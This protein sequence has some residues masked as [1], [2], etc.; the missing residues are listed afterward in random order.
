M[1]Q[2]EVEVDG[3]DE[4]VAAAAADEGADAARDAV[5]TTLLPK[6]AAKPR[7]D[8]PTAVMA[9]GEA[10]G[11]SG[12]G[13]QAQPSDSAG[14]PGPGRGPIQ[15]FA[16]DRREQDRTGDRDGG[17]GCSRRALLFGAG[18][19]GVGAA[20][21]A[22]FDRLR[23][24]GNA[25]SKPTTGFSPMADDGRS[26]ATQTCSAFLEAWASGRLV[27]A[28]NI[29]DDPARA[30]AALT[31]YQHELGVSGMVITPDGANSV[32]RMTFSITAQ[33]GKPA[34][35]WAYQSALGAYQRQVQG[36]TRWFVQWDPAILYSS[37]KTG[38]QL[39][40][41]KV[42]ATIKGLTDRSGVPISPAEH[43]SLAGFVTSLVRSTK[44]LDSTA[45]QQI[46][47]TDAGGEQLA[48]VTTLT[49]PVDDETLTT[50]FDM[51]V[52]TA[53]EAALNRDQSS[54]VAIQP[55]TGHILAI[56][57]R[58]G[59]GYYDQAMETRVAP[60]STFK[61]VTSTALLHNNLT[62]VE[63]AVPCP[64][65]LPVQGLTLKNSG[66]ESGL[67]NT[68]LEDFAASCNNAFSGFWDEGVT[69]D[70]LAETA[71]S[72]YGLNQKWDIGLGEPTQY[73]DV[74]TGLSGAALAESLVGQGDVL[75]STVAMCSVGA[76][77]ANGSFMQ[78]I[79]LPTAKQIGATA[80]PESLK[81]QL[82][83]LMA[84]VV[85]DG[86]T[87]AGVGFPRNGHFFAKTGTAEVDNPPNS[88][89]S[90]FVV[91]DDEH[92][93][94]LCTLSIDAGAGAAAAAPECLSVF[95]ALGY[96]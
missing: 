95:K 35:Q 36:V 47:M 17:G 16:L 27:A 46:I 12:S 87:A 91:F 59:S 54:L 96:A 34:G 82:W 83:Q 61:I 78:P 22:L 81:Q 58:T 52:Q 26:P 70:M 1:A 37:L 67:G 53:A 10:D 71:Q 43:P 9:A 69:P 33:A 88:N 39:K 38:Y 42:A 68:Y 6:V 51:K 72:F 40:I 8:E 90:W 45:G 60:G 89:N 15:Q 86:G 93:I 18:A 92:D 80:L 41:A 19:V 77:V 48:T 23:A 25:P 20:G 24:S 44:A 79:V 66:T 31:A 76:T 65:F 49:D 32:G 2:Q 4:P 14:G 74:P 94:C 21:W 56:A 3:R 7:A 30:L 64:E 11:G 73:M 57:N 50:T 55:S 29:T 5:V 75:A 62:T 85:E 28:A 84:G 63:K 13:E